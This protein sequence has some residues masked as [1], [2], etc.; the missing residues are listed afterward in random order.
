MSSAKSEEP[1]PR[2]LR[3]AREEGDSG[4]S[5]YASQ[6]VGLLVAVLL[7]PAAVAAL[8]S[9][10]ESR[11]RELLTAAADAPPP[12]AV[13]ALEARRA[14]IDVLAL[15]LP[16]LLAVALA[17]GAAQLV[18]TGGVLATKRIG[19]RLER[20]N[21]FDGLLELVTRARLFA[22]ARALVL[23]PLVA[24]LV[25]HAL[26]AHALDLARISGRMEYVG[27]AAASLAKGVAWGATLAGLALAGV[28]VAFA[29]RDLRR[30]LRMSRDE[31]KREAKEADG[32]PEI[33]RGR[34]QVHR[35]ILAS[36]DVARVKRASLVIVAPS[37]SACAL[38]YDADERDTA[39]VVVVRG[40]GLLVEEMIRVARAH[41]VSV[42]DDP[43][44]ARALSELETGDAIPEA[45]YDDVADRMR[46]P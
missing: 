41:G 30:R 4:A 16:V 15:A 45:L 21:P 13:I 29:R 32:D 28:D 43:P 33:R 3:R 23:A 9:R 38:R 22:V 10:V 11:L 31:I 25:L 2:R 46:A 1:T 26:R 37:R 8:A 34:E 44:L 39:P 36:G 5:A 7:V 12:V 27:K 42:V 17:A 40:D 19:L 6:A 35:E 14:A 20:L 24:W 18:Q